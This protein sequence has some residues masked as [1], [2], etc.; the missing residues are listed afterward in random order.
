MRFEGLL[1]ER[2][3]AEKQK[4]LSDL[5]LSDRCIHMGEIGLDKRFTDLLSM[6]MQA[7][8]LREELSFA[9]SNNKCVSLHCVQ[10]T[11]MMLQILS[12]FRFRPFSVIWHGFTGSSETARQLYK[13]GVIISIGPRFHGSIRSIFEANPNTVP[14]TDYEGQDESEY[15]SVLRQQYE[16]FCT[17]LG[18]TLDEFSVTSA[19]TLR[20]LQCIG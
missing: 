10:A 11:G 9:F 13:A 7:E 3:T 15:Q 6:E 2:W 12:E 16:R 17:E 18:M 8:V 5:L 20:K 19:G 1:P 4:V 14:E